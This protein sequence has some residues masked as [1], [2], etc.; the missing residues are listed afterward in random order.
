M[1]S[2]YYGFYHIFEGG[3]LE[4]IDV[5]IEHHPLHYINAYPNRV[6]RTEA[7]FNRKIIFNA[8][9]WHHV[10]EVFSGERFVLAVNAWE[11][12]PLKFDDREQN[13]GSTDQEGGERYKM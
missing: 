6:V 4:T 5:D 8:T 3:Y 7:K 13:L 2:V 1:G 9:L 10:S 12:R 11:Q